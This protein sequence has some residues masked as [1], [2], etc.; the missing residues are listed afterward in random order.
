MST[1]STS[2]S[3]HI[4]NMYMLAYI[5]KA[6]RTS[7]HA[8]NTLR[9]IAVAVTSVAL[10]SILAYPIA[11]ASISATGLTFTATYFVSLPV[12]TF[13]LDLILHRLN[14][15]KHWFDIR[16]AA[17]VLEPKEKV[18]NLAFFSQFFPYHYHH[19]E[20]TKLP[21]SP[22][23]PAPTPSGHPTSVATRVP[24]Q[25][26]V[27]IG[28]N[29]PEVK[30]GQYRLSN[31]VNDAKH[32]RELL[33]NTGSEPDDITLMVDL[34][35]YKAKE[36]YPTKQNIINQIKAAIADV[37]AA[38]KK[39]PNSILYVH[40]SG[41][42]TRTPEKKK[43]SEKDGLDDD[44]VAADFEFI[45]DDELNDLIKTL[46]KDAAAV[47]T[48]DCCH[49]G[50]MLDLPH[51]YYFEIASGKET[52][53]AEETTDD[54]SFGSVI[55]ISGCEDKETSADGGT[56]HGEGSG[57]MTAAYYSTLEEHGYHLTVR[58][59][60]IG[61]NEKIQKSGLKQHPQ[62]SSSRKLDLDSYFVTSQIRFHPQIKV[63]V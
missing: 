3:P 50:S 62:I 58:Q 16:A 25:R 17:L 41:H 54:L 15:S 44:M 9:D 7:P 21:T 45:A 11:A 56:V 10:A 32:I 43:G 40:D 36:V 57:A 18:L 22:A 31:C 4:D 55:M 24:V 1:P 53:K 5:G 37:N 35:E 49:S 38:I 59:L 33:L 46:D 28:C 61:M 47:F 34:S 27:V 52:I 19:Q 42:G 29:Y 30:N 6:E 14:Q 8:Y 2:L 39:N 20:E 26:A 12:L 63:K 23:K 48:L 13:A 51:N 60:L